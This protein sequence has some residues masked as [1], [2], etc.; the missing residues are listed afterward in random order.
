MFVTFRNKL[1]SQFAEAINKNSRLDLT[2]IRVKKLYDLE[3]VEEVFD[4]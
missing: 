4:R 1:C 3:C 2:S